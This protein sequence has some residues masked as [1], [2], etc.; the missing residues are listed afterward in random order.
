VGCTARV[1]LVRA[2]DLRVRG[3]MPHTL[4]AAF[5]VRMLEPPAAAE[6]E[7]EQRKL[8]A[9]PR[10]VCVGV[11]LP[12]GYVLL[13]AHGTPLEDS[14]AGASSGAAAPVEVSFTSPLLIRDALH[15]LLMSASVVYAAWK[16]D[17]LNR[18]LM[19]LFQQQAAGNSD[20]DDDDE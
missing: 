9:A 8:D 14:A 10:D 15:T 16:A 6:E 3:G 13:H 5:I 2:V 18:K 7:E 12:A 4:Q 19:E 17:E 11:C 1:R 20:D